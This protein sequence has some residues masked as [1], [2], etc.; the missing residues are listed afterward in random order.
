MQTRGDKRE[1]EAR[2]GLLRREGERGLVA[3]RGREGACCGERGRR[4]RGA[5]RGA[6]R[7]EGYADG[8]A[9]R[10]RST[11]VLV[12]CLEATLRMGGAALRRAHV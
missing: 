3:V 9:H 2:G 8:P 6:G 4:K 1:Q 10:G 7:C 5:S 11:A 12:R